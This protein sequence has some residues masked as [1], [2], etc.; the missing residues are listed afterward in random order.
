MRRRLQRAMARL[1]R[2]A[3]RA[4]QLLF[5]AADAFFA[6][7]GMQLAAAISYYGLFALFPIAILAVAGFSLI[8]GEERARTDVLAFLMRNLPVTEG[9]GREDLDRLLRSVTSGAEAF[10]IVGLAGLVFSASGLMAAVRHGLNTAW[11]TRD[12]RPPLRG[13]A[14]DILLVLA[15]GLIVALSL[16][17]TFG[18]RIARAFTED[19]PRTLGDVSDVLP[20]LVAVGGRLVPAVVAF[21]AFLALYRFVPA[22]TVRTRDAAVGALVA[23]IGFELTKR[24]FA[25]YLDRVASFGAVYGSLA[26]AVAMAFF[27][28]VNANVFLFGAEVAARWPAVRDAP[29]TA[30]DGEPFGRRVLRFLRGLVLE[31]RADDARDPDP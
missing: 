25:F 15:L 22:T 10:G 13:K 17:L 29:D 14:F 30:G 26:T 7:R 1:G 16:L 20:T 9:A 18:T 11:E 12:P 31:E 23:A 24:G 28:F 4:A 19:L 5:T 21:A 6:H 3:G 27:V 8:L 2:A